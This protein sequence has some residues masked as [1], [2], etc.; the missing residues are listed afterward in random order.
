M[1]LKRVN[2][3]NYKQLKNTTV[4]FCEPDKKFKGASIRFL[5]GGNGSGKSA[6]FEAIGLIFTR[7]IHDELP[8]FHFEIEYTIKVNGEE[9]DIS[10][11]P[12]LQGRT[13]KH[14]QNGDKLKI[15]ITSTTGERRTFNS[16]SKL[17]EYHPHRII[18]YSSGPNSIMLDI[19]LTSPRKSLYS[20]ISD[21]RG[22]C[23]NGPHA[24]AQAV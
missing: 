5:I 24:A 17:K 14:L 1:R 11:S 10:V 23:G 15:I 8:G 19:L 4:E 13:D 18:A 16:F 6:F 22:I 7:I 3:Q 21:Y 2:I 9:F 20:D 12:S